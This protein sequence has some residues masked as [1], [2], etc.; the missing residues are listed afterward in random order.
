MDG[1]AAAVVVRGL[2]GPGDGVEEVGER[3]SEAAGAHLHGCCC[4]SPRGG[5]GGVV[6]PWVTLACPC[7]EIPLRCSRIHGLVSPREAARALV[8]EGVFSAE[9]EAARGFRHITAKILGRSE[10][11]SR[12]PAPPMDAGRVGGPSD[13]S[14][15]QL[16]PGV[17]LYFACGI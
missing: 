8:L 11:P 14:S 5:G 7:T 10:S 15:L 6:W 13:L 17:V 16:E 12:P 4:A 9:R 2:E 1:A 3:P